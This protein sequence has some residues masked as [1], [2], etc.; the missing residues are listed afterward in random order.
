M[1]WRVGTRTGPCLRA[2]ADSRAHCATP[3]RMDL[4]GI[5]FSDNY[6]MVVLR[7]DVTVCVVVER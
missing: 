1:E 4:S 3:R 6:Q 2:R 7:R 5:T